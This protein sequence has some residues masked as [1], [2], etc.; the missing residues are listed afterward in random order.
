MGNPFLSSEQLEIV[1][2]DTAETYSRARLLGVVEERSAELIALGV[3]RGDRV[4]TTGGN[5]VAFFRD[6]FAIWKLGG[7]AIPLDPQ[8]APFEKKRILDAADCGWRID[9]D[10]VSRRSSRAAAARRHPSAQLLLYTSGSTG[11]PKAAAH[12]VQTLHARCRSLARCIPPAQVARTLCLVPTFFGHGLVG[13]CLFPLLTGARLVLPQP[14]TAAALPFLA[15]LIDDE[16]ITF[17]S[18]VPSLWELVLAMDRMPQGGTL[19]RIHCASAPLMPGRAERIAAWAPTATL[20][21]VYGLTEAASWI[22]GAPLSAG[23]EGVIGT[24]WGAELRLR[25]ATVQE[26]DSGGD[27]GTRVGQVELRTDSMMLGY[28]CADEDAGQRLDPGAWFATHDLGRLH[29]AGVALVG[30][31]K[32][33]INRGGLKVHPE[34]VERLL[35]EVPFVKESCVFAM[36]DP[37]YGQEVAAAIHCSFAEEGWEGSLERALRL[38]IDPR[39]IPKKWVLVDEIPRTSRG[40]LDR[41]GL[42]RTFG[43]SDG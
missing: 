38:R 4:A 36:H 24:G 16:A 9:G 41:R 22:A 11:A 10:T 29:P 18:T 43:G 17:F 14:P 30:R 26:G 20:Y 32:T 35:A 33:V 42:S 8:L 1:S 25:E 31:A 34:D 23:Q 7:C 3:G 5:S 37:I 27:P 13:N 12:T 15:E 2:L 21:N 19:R 39:K 6:L 40:K 28:E